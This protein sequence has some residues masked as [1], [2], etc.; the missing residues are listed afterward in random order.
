MLI[1]DAIFFDFDGTLVD[2]R[3]DIVNAVN[4]TLAR[5][6]RPEKPF[7]EVVS[8]IG[9]GVSYLVS[10]SLG[11]ED[12]GLVEEG[13]RIYIDYYTAHPA[14]EA[15]VYPHAKEMLDFF[16]NKRK[17][18]LTNRYVSLAAPALEATGLGKYFE[19]VIG[20]DDESCLKP[21]ACVFDNIL[22]RLK[23]DK[24]RAIIVGDMAV[25][26]MAGKNSG[27]KTCWVTYG[28][29]RMADLEGVKPD[30]VIDDI[31]ELKKIIK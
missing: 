26:I 29:G 18:I 20:G 8:Y 5:L 16:R 4:Y 12:A 13:V 10:K 9:T 27:I 19:E 17:F 14:D 30:Y 7:T 6:G 22:P 28:L 31:A 21:S 25:D 2:A 11:S 15:V 1:V 3:I 23:V 24:K